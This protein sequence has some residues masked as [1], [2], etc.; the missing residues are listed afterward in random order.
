M[1]DR[2]KTLSKDLSVEEF[3]AFRDFI[4]QHAGIFLEESKLDSLRISIVT[5]ATRMELTEITEYLDVLM[6]DEEEFKELL[7]LITI[8]E[9]SFFR[10]PAQFEALRRRVIPEIIEGKPPGT[11]LLRAW[12]AGC[13]TGE[14]PYTIAM[15]LFDSGIEGLGW[16]AQVMGTDVS[17]KALGVAR[18]GVYKGKALVNLKSDQLARHFVETEDGYSVAQHARRMVDF[19]YHN[20]IKEP[21]PLALM[22]NWDIIFCR[23]VTIYFRLESTRRV[24]ANFHRS[25]NEGGYLFIGHSETLSGIS[26]DFEAI[27][28]DGVYLHRKKRSG[29]PMSFPSFAFGDVPPAK[30]AE[31]RP[32]FEERPRSKATRRPP[33]AETEPGESFDDL[34]ARGRRFISVGQHAEGRAALLGAVEIDPKNPAPHLLLAVS[35]ADSGDLEEA[36]RQCENALA[37]NPLQAS[38]RYVLGM[39]HQQAGDLAGAVAEFKKTVYIDAD[40][41]LAHLNLGNIYKGQSR[42]EAACRSYENAV[43]SL[44]RSPGGPWTEFMGGFTAD[45]IRKTCERSLIEC[46]KAAGRP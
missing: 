45:L 4:H 21:Y 32:L 37:V 31:A 14:E 44:D 26:S 11:K 1:T 7:N 20:L 36:L 23:N 2:D 16:E 30:K 35:H 29:R 46:R 42:M 5:R 3:R 28:I 10:F 19:G 27:E 43:A 38:A 41:V 12:S 9:T 22:G 40:F 8:N 39:I 15:T 6:Y 17:T 25:L 33:L 24:V 18:R 34:L 13:S